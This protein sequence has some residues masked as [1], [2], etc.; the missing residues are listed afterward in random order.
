M[1]FRKF[2]VFVS[3][4]FI[5]ATYSEA[6]IKKAGICSSALLAACALM[7]GCATPY[8]NPSEE[9]EYREESS[10][11][12]TVL[13]KKMEFEDAEWNPEQWD[14]RSGR[15][16]DFIL[17]LN[18]MRKSTFEQE[19][20]KTLTLFLTVLDKKISLKRR[21]EAYQLYLVQ[22]KK[23]ALYAGKVRISF[24]KKSDPQT[25]VVFYYPEL[26][27]NL[28]I[29]QDAWQLRRELSLFLEEGEVH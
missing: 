8:E 18:R 9:F 6:K 27:T 22:V 28:A 3:L 26:L 14:P 7:S 21:K 11:P 15:S 5:F 13:V 17:E 25:T 10:L 24:I 12:E 23:A 1:F 4:T 20:A 19:H 29:A 16:A 2:V